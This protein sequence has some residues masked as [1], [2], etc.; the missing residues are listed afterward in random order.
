M[1]LL[2]LSKSVMARRKSYH[3]NEE[4]LTYEL[5]K[6]SFSKKFLRFIALFG[7][8]LGM[9]I[10]YLYLY[11][12]VLGFETPK[13][14]ILK[15]ETADWHSKLELLNNRFENDNA[16]LMELQMR[17]GV[18]Y[19]PIFG[20]EELTADVRNAGYGGVD[21]YS[22]FEMMDRSGFLAETVNKIDLLSK[23]AY[24][25]SRSLDDVSVLAKMTEEMAQCIPSIPPV[26]TDRKVIHFS[27]PFGMRKDPFTGN[28]KFH[29][30]IDLASPILGEP[31]YAS[32]NGT[33]QRVGNDFFGYGNFIIID[34]GFGYK[35]R[36]GHLKKALVYE[37]QKI[38]R[39]DQI[40]EMGNTGHS[41]GTHL[42]YEVIYKNKTVNPLNYFNFD[43]LPED[44]ALMVKPVKP[45]G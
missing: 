5:L 8:S 29:A 32:G 25:Q 11:T 18:V 34:H 3:F 41:K 17:D 24:V 19:R 42:H 2:Y 38:Q 28:Y 6:T 10:F 13:T 4:T 36:Y 1:Q 21:R 15:R 9:F 43:I 7:A 12:D 30:G 23:K 45:R 27:S 26:T 22:Q 39:G 40:G 16:V 31:I 44:Y 37:G 20:M 35:T 14:I 33:V